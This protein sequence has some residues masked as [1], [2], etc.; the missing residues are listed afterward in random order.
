[1]QGFHLRRTVSSPSLNAMN[2]ILLICLLL[3][4]KFCRLVLYASRAENIFV[5]LLA[6]QC[7]LNMARPLNR[8]LRQANQSLCQSIT[9]NVCFIEAPSGDFCK[10]KCSVNIRFVVCCLS[11]E[12]RT[13]L[14]KRFDLVARITRELPSIERELLKMT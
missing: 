4:C 12:T 9:D 13:P 2:E 7:P 1:M 3:V 10:T 6:V 5:L 8:G 14:I 11:M